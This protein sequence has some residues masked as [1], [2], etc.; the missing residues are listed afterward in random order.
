MSIQRESDIAVIGMACVFPGAGD[1]CRYWENI[2]QKFDAIGEPPPEWEADYY[3]DAEAGSNDRTYTIRGGFLGALAEFH[4]SEFGVM[5][6][7]IDGSDPDHFMALRAAHEALVDAGYIGSPRLQELKERTAVVIGRGTYINRGNTTMMQQSIVV[8]GVV[9][10]LGQLFPE[11]SGDELAEIR[12]NLKSSLPPFHADTA[13][14]L[15]PN[16]ISGRIA[17]R[18]DLMGPNYIVDAACASSLVAIDQAIRELRTGRCDMAISGGTNCTVSPPMMIQF[19]QL[20]ALSRRGKISPFGSSADGTLLG[21]GVGMVVLRRLADA[22]RDG[23]R[24]Y[25]LIKG[26]GT[27]SDGRAQGLLAPRLEGEELALRRAYEE[28]GVE[29]STVGLV[30][31]HGTATLIGDEVELKALNRVFGDRDTET[32]QCALGSVKSMIS[33]TMPAAG[34]AG[35][36]KV[37]LA[38]HHKILPPTLHCDQPNPKLPLERSRFY[39]NTETRPWIHG[40]TQSPR[41]AGVNA[42]GFGGVNSHTV[43]EEYTGPN[44][45]KWIHADWD[46]ECFVV[47]ANSAAEL[48]AALRHT[49]ELV[50]EQ[51]PTA[52]LADI[53]YTLNCAR[54]LGP[55]RV[56]L[57]AESVPDL[58]S[59]LERAGQVLEHT[60]DRS[61]RDRSG[62]YYFAET[63]GADAK[64]AFLF[65]GEGSQYENMLADLCLHFPEV[66]AAFDFMETAFEDHERGYRLKD[67]VFP[68][69]ADVGKGT[70]WSRM[71]LAV[72]AVFTA[73]MALNAL[74][75]RLEIRPRAMVGHSTG[76]NVALL[77]SG[78]I[79]ADSE[80]EMIRHIRGV[81]GVFEALQSSGKIPEG[82]LLSVAGANGDVLRTAI[83]AAD[84]EAF[85]ALQNCPH[86]TVVCGSQK[87]IEAVV[88]ALQGQPVVCQTLPWARAYHTPWFDV[89][90]EPTR[91]YYDSVEFRTPKVPLYSCSLAEE[92]PAAVNEARDTAACQWARTV[93]FQDTV[94]TL[95]ESG[96]RI[97]IEV[98]PKGNLTSFVDDILRGRPHLCLPANLQS[99]T[100]ILQLNH[101]VGQLVAHQVPVNLRRLYEH[102]SARDVTQKVAQR[103]PGVVLRTDL[104]PIR[105]PSGFRLSPAGRS[106]L[107]HNTSDSPAMSPPPPPAEKPP[108]AAARI[109]TAPHNARSAVMAE[110][111]QTM[112]RFLESQRQVLSS[113]QVAR[114]G[115]TA[116]RNGMRVAERSLPPLI[117]EVQEHVPGVRL[118]A[119]HEFSLDRELM[120]RDHVL[121]RNVSDEDR[122]LLALP[123]VPLTL[124]LESVAETA[125]LLKPG[126]AVTGIREFRLYR[127]G[128]LERGPLPMEYS[129]ECSAEGEISVV[130]RDGDRSKPLRPIWA[131]AKVDVSDIYPE[132]PTAGEFSLHEERPSKLTPELLYYEWM[133]HGPSFQ[134]VRRM[135]R[136]GVDGA[137]ATLLVKQPSTLIAGLP[138]PCFVT[139][140]VLI[141]VAGQVLSFWLQ[142][143]VA[144]HN[145]VYPYRIGAL[146]CFGP[147]PSPGQEVECRVRVR[148]LGEREVFADIELVGSDSRLLYRI[149]NWEDRRWPQDSEFWAL[150]R[151]PRL[152]YLSQVWSTPDLP[153]GGIACSYIGGFP[154]DFGRASHG[155][156]LSVV[157]HLVLSRPERAEWHRM[158][159][160]A[161]CREQWLIER[162][163]I[164]D[165]VRRLM[166]DRFGE[167]LCPADVEVRVGI[168]GILQVRGAWQQRLGAT[169]SVCSV[170][171]NGG[172]A[173]AASLE[174]ESCGKSE[175]ERIAARRFSSRLEQAQRGHF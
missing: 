36:I 28:S 126:K 149:T 141:D 173:A 41:R 25:A 72:E 44:Q 52:R 61:V 157:A 18:L 19:S 63:Y 122:D 133:F 13:P 138:A 109:A 170:R 113:Y 156:W 175:L 143:R 114:W 104:N 147:P 6:K 78:V 48:P 29:P 47:T 98:G 20:G 70:L 69:P 117:T 116:G 115:R 50:A 81:N 171:E 168:D 153:V 40:S 132:A 129:A 128:S 86:Q 83:E 111:F 142:E 88:E 92:Y 2:I 106:S 159:S 135:L 134:G 105:L 75:E 56:C 123:V 148:H 76:E 140:P 124:F 64:V 26:V 118:L 62:I 14:S 84:G 53:A 60:P 96:F 80:E 151:E 30:E 46:S 154:E 95:Y 121:G 37:A 125:A 145:D 15:V 59:K 155:I 1:L 22:E 4:P 34:A 169:P 51:G 3:L 43:L 33:H 49:H 89:F 66:R 5:P 39:L 77:C 97:F 146:E 108:E 73:D 68:P 130:M 144:S 58:L 120:I 131:E 8:D 93:R 158:A 31:G 87:G 24:I 107:G 16:I 7:S 127:W 55:R 45:A 174:R 167:E 32:P 136:T 9:R 162:C 163:A 161:E 152:G 103:S 21:E 71:D 102:R 65:P 23:D 166:K 165:S 139:D 42:F 82:Q 112:A 12:A 79:A 17:N 27:A 150:R 74:L 90:S 11:Y 54:D 137:T 99:R 100:G 67:A 94:E 35:L 119:R 101:M 85:V 110:H 10:I 172:V 91:R 160:T 164:K 38:L 57:V